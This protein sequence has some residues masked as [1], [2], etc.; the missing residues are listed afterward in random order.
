M[1]LSLQPQAHTVEQKQ[2]LRRTLDKMLQGIL[3]YYIHVIDYV[4]ILLD[5]DNETDEH[6]HYPVKFVSITSVV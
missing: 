5:S 4:E 3:D 1:L 2:S 6:T